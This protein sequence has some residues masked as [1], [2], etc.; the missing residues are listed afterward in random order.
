MI[1]IRPKVD[2]EVNVDMEITPEIAE[3]DI[4]T[5]NNFI[6]YYGKNEVPLS[7]LFEVEMATG[8]DGGDKKIILEG[9]FSR[10]KWVG[11]G[12]FD[13]EIHVKGDIGAD[14]GAYM[15][16]GK[17]I[18]EGN[19]DD[20]LGAEMDGGEILVKGNVENCLACPYW[21]NTEGMKG[22]KITIKGNAG[23]YIGEKM[24]GGEIA[25]HGSAGDFIGTEMK[26]GLITIK[27]SCGITG[28]DMKGGEIR[29]GGNFDIVPSFR[30]VEKGYTGDTNV[31]GKGIVIPL[32]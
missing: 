21:G 1:V 11:K 29:I 5:V 13:G 23:S 30:K 24:M 17:I 2:L 19:A 8:A 20:W 14:C 31:K 9:D 26:N 32:D 18:I 4:E 16:G 10:V 22:G 28:G 12:M 25:I 3:S 27:G 7:E 15:K 6:V